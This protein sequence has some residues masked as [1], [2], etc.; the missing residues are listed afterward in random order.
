MQDNDKLEEVGKRVESAE[1]KSRL[2]VGERDDALKREKEKE[3]ERKELFQEVERQKFAFNLATA[4]ADRLRKELDALKQ[5]NNE[6]EEKTKTTGRNKHEEGYQA[7]TRVAQLQAELKKQAEKK[8]RSGD[9]EGL[10]GTNAVKLEVRFDLIHPGDIW[11][12]PWIFGTERK[13]LQVAR[14]ELNRMRTMVL[15]PIVEEMEELKLHIVASEV[16]FS[17]FHNRSPT[18]QMEMYNIFSCGVHVGRFIR[19]GCI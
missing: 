9:I 3:I 18:E 17:F 11:C 15:M 12:L 1:A 19:S 5:T 6:L 7:V 4:D 2:L 10:Q 16:I 8:E 14:R 13:H